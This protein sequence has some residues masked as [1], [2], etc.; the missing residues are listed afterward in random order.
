MAE[1]TAEQGPSLIRALLKGLT[2]IVVF[3]AVGLVFEHWSFHDLLDSGWVDNSVRG[4]GLAGLALFLGVGALVV[5][6]GL[7]RQAVCFLAGYGFGLGKGFVLASAASLLGCAI[8][9]FFA[10]F[11]AR[12]LVARRL[13]NRARRIDSFLGRNPFSTTV[14]IRFLPVGSNVL[15]NLLA[16][17]SSVP[18]SPFLLGSLVGYVPQTVV[19]ALLGSGVRVQPTLRFGIGLALFLISAVLGVILYRRIGRSAAGPEPPR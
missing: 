16:G 14:M 12:D 10:R 7:P 4:K 19:F 18:P 13:A 9:F 15:T 6:I 3:V 2:L 11:L 8:A 5:A 17:L 1:E